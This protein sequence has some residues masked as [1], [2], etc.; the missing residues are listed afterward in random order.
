MEK[1]IFYT[2]RKYKYYFNS[3]QLIRFIKKTLYLHR[4]LIKFE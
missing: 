4:Y 1:S 2:Y 3:I